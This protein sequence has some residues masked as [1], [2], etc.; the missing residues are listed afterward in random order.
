M[1]SRILVV[2]DDGHLGRQISDMLSFLGLDAVVATSGRDAISA[3]RT[4]PFDVIVCD[5]MLPG[6]NGVQ[7]IEEIR[8][9]PLGGSVPVFL[10]SAVYTNP[11]VFE[12]EL[13][14]LQILEFVPKPFSVIELGRKVAAV[15]EGLAEDGRADLTA[16]GSWKLAD[17]GIALGDGS[18]NFEPIGRFTRK[19]LLRVFIEIFSGHQ[20]GS[21]RLTRGRS[22]RTIHFLNGYPV[23]VES[24]SR[25]EGIVA[26]LVRASII[27]ASEG[28]AVEREAAQGHGSVH[29]HLLRNGVSE[30]R[31]LQAERDRVRHLVV[32]CFSS[33]S[34]EYHFEPGDGFGDRL[35]IFETNPVRCLAEA[36]ER[37]LAVDEVS[38]EVQALSSNRLQAGSKF[39]TLMPYVVLPR[40]LESF[41]AEL[42]AEPTPNALFRRFGPYAESLI[43]LLWLMKELDIV[44]AGPPESKT[45]LPTV[46]APLR[47]TAAPQAPESVVRS[48]ASIPAVG[49]GELDRRSRDILAAYLSRMDSDYYALL[50]LPDG[51]EPTLVRD[52][53]DRG[54][55]RFDSSLLDPEA[56]SEVREKC[57]EL[58]GRVERAGQTLLDPSRRKLYDDMRALRVT[59]NEHSVAL[60]VALRDAREFVRAG[61]I[62]EALP[63][64]EGLRDAHPHSPLVLAMLGYSL[65]R[66]HPGDSQARL[67][68]RGL[69]EQSC[70]LDPTG[71]DG[72]RYLGDLC[73]EMGDLASAQRARA[74]LADVEELERST[75]IDQA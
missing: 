34:G 46:G 30:R 21:L 73:E 7:T 58:R 60:A 37:W 53:V 1:L 32:A 64:L 9:L 28:E 51:A 10:T 36:V 22:Q 17:L 23:H 56:P 8:A 25:D 29:D 27:T 35:G 20:A 62:Q 42:E 43:K 54:R 68:A 49:A 63:L 24:E 2:E 44:R 45:S 69:L 3:F 5:L 26:A 50:D 48:G 72:L 6:L 15:A 55:G 75:E 52:A 61:R 4:T 47:P 31:L 74:A 19:S 67:H 71:S 66:A 41:P 16:T 39:R 18:E 14:R 57:K 13:R 59:G 12:R 38:A 70:A 40:G 33:P 11:R 65:W